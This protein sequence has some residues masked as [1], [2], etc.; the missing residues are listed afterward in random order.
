MYILYNFIKF[1]YDN[2]SHFLL[3]IEL[4]IPT[5]TNRHF[6]YNINQ[7]ERFYIHLSSDLNI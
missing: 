1:I 7:N 2:Y 3:R 4:S 5:T 6:N